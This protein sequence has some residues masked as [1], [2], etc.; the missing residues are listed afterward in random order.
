MKNELSNKFKKAL[1]LVLGTTIIMSGLT[2]CGVQKQ[3]S[4]YQGMLKEGETKSEY[5]KELFYR[6][7]KQSKI[8]DP[9][10]LDNT[11]RDGY[12]YAY[13]T[14]G[15][16]FCYRSK[17]LMDWEAVGN[18]LADWHYESDGI[19]TVDTKLTNAN[20]WAPEVV[21][22][23]ETNKYYMYF[24]ATPTADKQVEGIEK[25]N[26][27]YTMMV[28]VSDY[29]DRG[30]KIVNFQDAASCGK[31]NVRFYD[32][33]AYPQYYAK[34]VL[35]DPAEITRVSRESGIILSERGGYSSTIDPH[36]Y[37]DDNGDKYLL[38]TSHG[39]GMNIVF[40]VKMINWLTP[41]WST[42]TAL[43]YNSYYTVEDY[44][45]AQAGGTVSR[46]S[47]ETE[48]NAVNEG[49]SVVKHNGKYYLT[50]SMNSYEDAAYQVGQAVA[51]TPLGP[52]R[53]LTEEEGGIL[54]SG[55]KAGSLEI[56]GTGHNS[57][58][59]V[60]EQMYIVY[61]RHDNATVGGA[62]RHHVID[63]IKW[64]TVK[65]KD[66][67]DLEV[68]YANGPTGT[69]QPAI[70]AF[71]EYK[72][73][74][75]EAKVSGSE[76][77]ACLTDGLLSIY[78]YGNE[79][80]LQNIKET[81]ISKKTTFEFDFD[82]ARTVRGVMV[83]NSKW[84]NTCFQKVAKV[85]FVCE[86]NG[87]EVVYYIEDMEFSSENYRRNDMDGLIYY[88]VPGAAAYAEFDE[89]NCTSVRITVE[90][91]EGQESVGISEIR[92]LGK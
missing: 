26:A 75:D 39:Q 59:T 51:D 92:I 30:Y 89:L 16:L 55:G 74:A 6:N 1:V 46:V 78:K 58:V 57:F 48:G 54:L 21:Y 31:E 23:K 28:A 72:N 61:H 68:M 65:D 35:F 86:E 49:A 73:I 47:Y 20:L 7:E 12:Y 18:T 15:F 90:V 42:A 84:E 81:S 4:N 70:E 64:I 69:V 41:D 34:Y 76:D 19:V 36:P 3:L 85:E 14:E 38:W 5:N 24:S 80:F 44:K 83:Y 77:V 53:K 79:T 63:E 66:G 2:G 40:G 71:S 43:L 29:P 32:A 88:I 52:Y 82:K 33:K 10:V 13:G 56:T 67:N 87:E 50:Y 45:T 25:G 62:S 8:A 37:E 11:E 22:D 60:G 9:F 17:N 91:P 27:N